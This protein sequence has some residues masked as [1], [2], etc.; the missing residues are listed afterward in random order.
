MILR[1]KNIMK[2]KNSLDK[3]LS[4]SETFS[5]VLS[6]ATELLVLFVSAQFVFMNILNELSDK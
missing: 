3:N 5:S 4:K 2:K 1:M 6:V